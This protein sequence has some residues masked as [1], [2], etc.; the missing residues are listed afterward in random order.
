PETV[1]LLF[2]AYRLTGD[3]KYCEQGWRIFQAINKYCKLPEGG[4]ATILEVENVRSELEDK[5]ETFFL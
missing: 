2:F 4:C 3:K 1:E 5:M